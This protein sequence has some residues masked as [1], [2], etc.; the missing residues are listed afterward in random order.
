MNLI[1]ACRTAKT[2]EKMIRRKSWG[3]SLDNYAYVGFDG[4]FF[5]C[6]GIPELGT[7]TVDFILTEDDLLDDWEVI[8]SKEVYKLY[9][10]YVAERNKAIEKDR[11]DKYGYYYPNS[12][13]YYWDDK[14]EQCR[15]LNDYPNKKPII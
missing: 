9:D 8:H 4:S 13:Q 11:K 7:V 15:Y 1:K 6:S 2:K 10:Q 3:K 12:R 5:Y 14:R